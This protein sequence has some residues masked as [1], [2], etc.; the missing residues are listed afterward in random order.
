MIGDSHDNE[1]QRKEAHLRFTG[2]QKIEKKG[3][4]EGRGLGERRKEELLCR[5][6]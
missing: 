1:E 3:E 2:E 4:D 6:C 5:F